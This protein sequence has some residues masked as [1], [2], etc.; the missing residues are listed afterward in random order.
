MHAL[1][2]RLMVLEAKV[3][4]RFGPTPTP[5]VIPFYEPEFNGDMSPFDTS[6][7]TGIRLDAVEYSRLEGETVEEMKTRV[8]ATRD[9]W[10]PF[11]FSAWMIAEAR[12]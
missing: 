9:D 6:R 2:K 11:V 12:Q 4:N 7:V 5:L 1:L 8:L 3:I 10:P